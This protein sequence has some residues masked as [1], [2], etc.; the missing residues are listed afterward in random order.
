MDWATD[1]LGAAARGAIGGLVVDSRTVADCGRTLRDCVG[2]GVG[3]WCNGL[4]GPGLAPVE[5]PWAARGVGDAA[6]EP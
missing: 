1:S 3:C 2:S 4:D 6:V 5:P